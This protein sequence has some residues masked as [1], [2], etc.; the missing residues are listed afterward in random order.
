MK[1]R[2]LLSMPLAFGLALCWAPALCAQ[3]VIS[4]G[5]ELGGRQFNGTLSS[6]K[7]TEY[8]DLPAGMFVNAFSL[9]LMNTGHVHFL[10]LGGSHVGQQ[11][12]NFAAQLGVR[13]R[14]K[15]ELEWGQAPHNYTN[16]A[17][18]VFTN[19]G[20]GELVMPDLLQN[21]LR[22][23]LTTDLNPRVSGVQFDT[24]AITDLVLGSARGVDV[25]SRRDRG[26]ATL[27]YSPTEEL[28]VKVHY[29]NEQRS[30]TKPLGGNFGFNP[31]ELL[32]PTD[33]RTQEVLT[34]LE[35]AAKGGNVQLGYSASLFDNNVDVLVWDNP[36]RE[37]DAVN[38]PSRG[39]TDLYPNNT[40]QKVSFSGAANLPS[41]TRLMATVSYGWRRQDDR[42]IPFTINAA[43]DTLRNFPRLPA[44]SLNGKVGT[45]LVNFSLTNRS[46][47]SVWLSARYR[48]F[49]YNNQTPGLVFPGYVGYDNNVSSVQ[50]RNVAIGYK[51]MNASADATL[52]PMRDVSLKVGYEREN[53]DRTHRDAEKTEENIYKASLDY[54]PRSGLLL[55]TS[56]SFGAKK[57]PHYD[58]EEVA[59]EAFPVGEP[60]GTL[61][62]LPQLRKFDMATRDRNRANVLAQVT[63]S[64]RVTFTTS[65]G[66]A[67]DRF[68]ESEYGLRRNR[69][70]NVSFDVSLSP[71]YDLAL[72]ASYTRENFNYAMRSRQRVPQA[73]ATPANDTPNNDW[74]SDLKDAVNTFGAG[75]SW[76]AVPE[77]VDVSLDFSSSDAKGIIATKALGNSATPGFLVTTA[78]DYPDT[79]SR[80]H[81]LRSSV[82]YR[83]SEHFTQRLEYRF[84]RY[85][86]SYFNQDV[87]T[88]YM[89]PVDPGTAGG[90]FLGARQPGYSAHILYL[91]LSSYF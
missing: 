68:K 8:R 60:A 87:M 58:W 72:F 71:T 55:R 35:Y 44:A 41:S 27:N 15:L 49:D 47:S 73:G 64:D 37:I 63:P 33:Y 59:H 86:E 1:T 30:G 45:T 39:R 20:S 34:S 89:L 25:V 4:G 28:D 80:L 52:R 38:N 26:K 12:Q 2:H 19:P 22:T 6:S 56:Y 21:R 5:A 40:A 29:S 16:T 9:N 76:S 48:F 31:V 61:G 42:F 50:R 53:W 90:V 82:G 43:L 91:V 46:S 79:R 36:F 24:L 51:K 32:E 18:T 81:Q 14:F 65:F 88:P 11:D 85:K 66:L 13:G 54:T 75:L 84:E 83:L 77:K 67:N 57:T 78:Q 74:G 69:S 62:Q 23:I 10:S 70:N 3:H 17:R 7:F